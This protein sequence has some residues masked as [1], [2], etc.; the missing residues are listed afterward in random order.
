MKCSC[1]FGSSAQQIVVDGSAVG[2]VGL[3]DIFRSWL[4]AGKGVQD[5]ANEQV[6]Q[7][8][9]KKNYVAAGKEDQYAE[10]IKARYAA[11]CGTQPPAAPMMA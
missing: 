11:F 1:G 4:R 7:E 5:L 3:D 10:A 6:L 2:V 8:I 9:R